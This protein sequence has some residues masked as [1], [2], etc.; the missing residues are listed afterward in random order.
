MKNLT[1]VLAAGLL[2][3]GSAAYA[4]EGDPGHE[5][6]EQGRFEAMKQEMLNDVDAQIGALQKFRDCLGAAADHAAAQKCHK[7]RHDAEKALRQAR[8]QERLKRIEHQQQELDKE[9]QRLQ[10]EDG[11]P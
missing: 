4:H 10:Q 8:R 5:K 6:D 7:E 1:V 2:L 11:K 3:A 9:K